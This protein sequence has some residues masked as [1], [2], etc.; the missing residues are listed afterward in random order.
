M[1][2]VL[3]SVA[4]LWSFIEKYGILGL[5]FLVI[6]Y[7]II[8]PEKAQ[9]IKSWFQGI[10]SFISSSARKGKISNNIVSRL[11]L[12]IKKQISFESKY[13]H[14]F[15]DKVRIQWVKEENA[16]SI[17]E[18]NNIIIRMNQKSTMKENYIKAVHSLVTTGFLAKSRKYVNKTVMD[19]SD[20]F[21]MKR[22]IIKG[23]HSAESL[24]DNTILKDYIERDLEIKELLDS[25][26]ALD[27]SGFLFPILINEYQKIGKLMFPREEDECLLVESKSFLLFLKNIANKEKDEWVDLEF[28]QNYFS[29]RCVLAVGM[30]YLNKHEINRRINQS[31]RDTRKGINTIYILGLGRK[32]QFA[33]ELAKNIQMS[34]LDIVSVNTTN[35]VNYNRSLSKVDGVCIELTTIAKN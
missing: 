19:A 35:I 11:N 25:I 4:E 24:F 15:P 27:R 2:I 21:M 20:I 33:E 9:L 8:Y 34:N 22:L 18:K 7:L 32:S 1:K 14:Y 12:A 16:E 10:F 31:I 29:I 17:L 26:I 5:L 3:W 6:L 30:P 13:E 23:Y 28:E